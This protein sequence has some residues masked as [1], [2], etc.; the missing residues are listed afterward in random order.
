MRAHAHNPCLLGLASRLHA[1]KIPQD[2]GI[3]AEYWNGG[4]C[5]R[6][7]SRKTMIPTMY[8]RSFVRNTAKKAA[9]D[10]AQE[11]GFRRR[12]EDHLA[13]NRSGHAD[14]SKNVHH[15]L[16]ERHKDNVNILAHQDPVAEARYLVAMAS[17]H[18]D[19]QAR[20]AAS[21][22]STQQAV[23]RIYAANENAEAF[24]SD[25]Q[26][27]NDDQTL[28]TEARTKKLVEAMQRYSDRVSG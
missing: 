26:A 7:T 3:S 15:V 8:P 5:R 12:V 17:L 18:Y 28:D 9:T 11:S 20:M 4:V 13:N 23:S 14:R 19:G 6:Q 2:L 25:L 21:V 1:P 10:S 27:I 16:R 24:Q 22:F